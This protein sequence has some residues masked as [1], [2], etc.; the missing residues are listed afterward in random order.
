M[1]A[2]SPSLFGLHILVSLL[3]LSSPLSSKQNGVV[4]G[5]IF[6]AGVSNVYSGICGTKSRF[7]YG[8]VQIEEVWGGVPY[9]TEQVVFLV[10]ICCF[11]IVCWDV[12]RGD[13]WGLGSIVYGVAGAAE[14]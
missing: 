12:D 7:R 4:V 10:V 2:V 11:S 5:N 14:H 8:A 13:Y 6:V 1:A 9:I 3:G